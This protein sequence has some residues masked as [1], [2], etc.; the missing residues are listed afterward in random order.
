MT[1]HKHALLFFS[2]VPEPGRTKTRL[3]VEHDGLLTPE[4]A[5]ELY[6][7][8][9]LDTA[10]VAMHALVELNQEGRADNA[11]D[12]VDR[13][14]FVVCTAPKENHPRMQA[15]FAA[16]GPWPLPITYI[17]DEGANFNEHFDNAFKQLWQMGYDSAVSIGGDLPQMPVGNVIQAFRWLRHFEQD[18]NGMGLVHCPCQA[19]GV[20]LVGMTRATP[21]DFAGVFYNTDGVSALDAIINTAHEKGLPMAALET[22]ADIDIVED[23]AHALTMARSQQYTSRFQPGVLPPKRFL[24]WAEREGYQAC[25]PPNENHDPREMIDA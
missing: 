2:K 11:A 10:E 4:Q 24:A 15:L 3:T 8:L 18:Y 13:Y 22:V 5:A 23:L 12:R 7:V 20:S 16:G 14:D 1:I 21:M 25:T 9:M 19:C 6:H 17:A